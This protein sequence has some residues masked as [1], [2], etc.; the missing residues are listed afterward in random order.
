MLSDVNFLDLSFVSELLG[1][2]VDY[3]NQAFSGS[4]GDSSYIAYATIYNSNYMYFSGKLDYKDLGGL[5]KDPAA[6]ISLYIRF[7]A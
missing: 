2:E 1:D 7:N 5:P 6:V 3:F 4:G